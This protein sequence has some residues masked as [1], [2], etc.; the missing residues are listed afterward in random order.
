M[1][2]MNKTKYLLTTTEDGCVIIAEVEKNHQ[3]N[4]KE[5]KVSQGFVDVNVSAGLFKD[6]RN[7]LGWDGKIW[8]FTEDLA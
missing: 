6:V 1:L 5:Y 7:M 3:H 2:Y 8:M 4:D